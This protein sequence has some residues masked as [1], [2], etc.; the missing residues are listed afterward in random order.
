MSCLR[1][2]PSGT[3]APQRAVGVAHVGDPAAVTRELHLAGRGA[4]QEGKRWVF[5]SQR[6]Q[7][8]T[9]A[10]AA[11]YGNEAFGRRG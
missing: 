4:A 5:A 8:A 1:S 6:M 10:R 2:V 9:R 11:A 7:L 3:T